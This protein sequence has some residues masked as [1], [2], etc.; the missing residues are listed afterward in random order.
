ME[1]IETTNGLSAAVETV[2]SLVFYSAPDKIIPFKN[3]SFGQ[4][5]NFELSGSNAGFIDVA[6]LRDNL[7]FL[8]KDSARIFRWFFS[9][10]QNNNEPSLWIN[11]GEKKAAGAK[12]IAVGDRVLVLSSDNSILEYRAGKL[13]RTITP[14][15]FPFP[16][17]FTR[18]ILSPL[19]TQLIILEP[20]QERVI[21]IDRAGK[22]I[23]Q[24]KSKEFLSLKDAVFSADNKNLYLLSG[25]KV[26]QLNLTD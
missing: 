3:N 9:N 24:F 20:G 17:K 11:P 1:T 14:S 22:L 7:Y 12:S 6:S 8:E 19:F 2:D 26:F 25:L 5:I 23:S 18:V 16:K 21:V 15:I 13:E 4:E 10:D